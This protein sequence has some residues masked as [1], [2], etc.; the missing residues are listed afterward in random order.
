VVV[1]AIQLEGSESD[2]LSIDSFGTACR[3]SGQWDNGWRTSGRGAAGERPTNE[4]IQI[5]VDRR[6]FGRARIFHVRITSKRL[7]GGPRL[8]NGPAAP[9]QRLQSE[10]NCGEQS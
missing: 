1:R 2:P 9:Q 8:D 4:A 10:Q 3:R 6:A 5:I 7:G